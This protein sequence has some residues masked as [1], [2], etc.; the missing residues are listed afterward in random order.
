VGPLGGVP[1]R[2]FSSSPGMNGGPAFDV[3]AIGASAGGVSALVLLLG[4]LPATF[5]VG[6]ALVLHLS[7]DRPSALIDVLARQTR[8][9]VR[10]AKD[11]DRVEPGVVV[12]AP[13][14]RHLVFQTDHTIS[15]EQTAPVHHS[16][17]SVDTLFSSAAHAFG[18]RTLAVVLTGNGQDGSDGVPRVHDRG[19]VVIA[20]DEASSQYFSMPHQAIASGGVSFVLPLKA[21]AP[22]LE[23]LV[24]LG[25]GAGSPRTTGMN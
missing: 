10:W 5:P 8:L 14:D 25:V 12:V 23:R 2:Q 18:P 3:V 21:I 7:P 24:A 9:R 13:P 4:D 15:L 22:A 16:R 11:G 17:P 20:Q 1:D 6:V 19:G